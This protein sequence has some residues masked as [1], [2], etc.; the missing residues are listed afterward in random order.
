MATVCF[1]L[2]TSWPFISRQRSSLRQVAVEGERARL[3]GAEFEH[4]RLA[5]A[6]ALGN[7]VGVDCEAVRDVAGVE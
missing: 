5:G 7:P 1:K 4:H 6:G 2:T 3:I